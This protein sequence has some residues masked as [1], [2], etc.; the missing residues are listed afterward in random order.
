M[1]KIG[2]LHNAIKTLLLNKIKIPQEVK[3]EMVRRVVKPILGRSCESWTTNE[4][5]RSKMNS[6]EMIFLRRIKE[7]DWIKYEMKYIETN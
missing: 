1:T 3:P 7:L 4:K 6:I 2:K 5:Q